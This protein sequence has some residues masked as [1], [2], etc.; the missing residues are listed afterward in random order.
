[1][2]SRQQQDAIGNAFGARQGDSAACLLQR[3]EVEKRGG[4][5]VGVFILLMACWRPCA[6]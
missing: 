6:N 5:H 4:K 3:G 1:A 2:Q